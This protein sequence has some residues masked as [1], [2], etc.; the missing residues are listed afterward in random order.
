MVSFGALSI[1]L[2]FELCKAVF[3]NVTYEDTIKETFVILT[4]LQKQGSI[5]VF[6]SRSKGPM[7]ITP[8]DCCHSW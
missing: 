1:Q 6:R 2:A 5:S 7:D 4:R 8:I 3:F